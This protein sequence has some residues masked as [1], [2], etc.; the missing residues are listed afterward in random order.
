MLGADG[1]RIINTQA[2][3]IRY[4]C[5]QKPAADPHYAIGKDMSCFGN[6]GAGSLISVPG[7]RV[8]NFDVFIAKNF[9]MK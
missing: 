7:T 1:N 2:F 4:P 8:L 5:C 9:P 6:A 3:T